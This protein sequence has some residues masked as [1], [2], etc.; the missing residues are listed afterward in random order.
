MII[1]KSELSNFLDKLTGQYQVLAPVK[2]G[3]EFYFQ[4]IRSGVQAD[5]SYS[6]SVT[7]P[8]GILF[9]QS[10]TLFNYDVQGET[11]DM[12][13]CLD[14]GKKVIFGLRPCDAKSLVLLDKVFHGEK[15]Q[16]PYYLSRRANTVLVG[17]G[18][19]E[20][21][22]TCFC[23]SLDGG[24][25]GTEGLDLLLVDIGDK[26][27]VEVVSEKGAS[28][29]TGASLPLAD[30]DDRA[31][32]AK[33]KETAF[34]ACTINLE[35][36]KEKMDVNYDDPVWGFLHEKCL[37]C[38]ACT[39]SCPTCHCFDIL[40]EVKDSTGC[41]VRNWDACMFPLFTVHGSG[42]NPRPTGKERFR[43]RFMHKFKYFVDNYGAFACVGCGR[44][45][46]NCPVNIDIRQVLADIKAGGDEK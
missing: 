15:Y 45:I 41:R 26:Y 25:F 10:E 21:R 19:G 46:L 16:D 20:P 30:K 38:G 35:G 44:C 34:Q 40:D 24:P 2:K 18:C 7:A 39:Y 9:P 11:A 8:K 32:A 36:L 22:G 1:K 33:A 23:A 12:Q 28:F 31:A 14:T 42:H 17:L 43:Q 6:N 5:L 13:E 37:G 29:L 27:V 3:L 4:P